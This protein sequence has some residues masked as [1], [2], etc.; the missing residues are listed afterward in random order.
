[1]M[2]TLT[3]VLA[4][5]A[6]AVIVLVVGLSGDR[7]RSAAQPLPQPLGR[8]GAA[9]PA[10]PEVTVRGTTPEPTAG[11]RSGAVPVSAPAGA[12]PIVPGA[13][14]VV[15]PATTGAPTEAGA[16]VLAA[17][18][19]TTRVAGAGSY[20]GE[21]TISADGPGTVTGWAV[22][23]TLNGRS[24]VT[25]ALDATF[26]QSGQTVTFRPL[27]NAQVSAASPVSFTFHVNRREDTTTAPLT[28]TI[29]GRACGS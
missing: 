5:L 11:A 28:C 8:T 23:I 21:I 12:S 2:G 18:Y 15:P 29:D 17:R 20:A 13:G 19:Q 7:S 16:T 6:L 10:S 3:A 9:T 26:A 1:M 24:K 25:D 14:P 22:V 27:G 4:M